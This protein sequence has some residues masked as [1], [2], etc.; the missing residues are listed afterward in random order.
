MSLITSI[1]WKCGVQIIIYLSGLQS[2]SPS[3][4]EA[5]RVDSATEWEMILANN[6][7]DADPDNAFKSCLFAG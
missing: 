3:L 4:Y 1:L 2:V 5:A 6:Y 7:A